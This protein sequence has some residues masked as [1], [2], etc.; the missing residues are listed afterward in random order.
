MESYNKEQ[1]Y[2]ELDLHSILRDLIHRSGAIVMVIISALMLTFM[3]TNEL[4]T[5]EYVTKAT[6]AITSKS[7]SYNISNNQAAQEAAAVFAKAVNSSI[8]SSK[9]AEL[10][11]QPKLP[12]T[13]SCEAQKYTNIAIITVTSPHPK[14][15]YEIMQMVL[16]NYQEVSQYLFTNLIVDVIEPAVLPDMASNTTKPLKVSLIVAFLS[17]VFMVGIISVLSFLRDTIKNEKQLEQKV[18]SKLFATLFF[19]YG[20]NKSIFSEFKKN[21][22]VGILITNPMTSFSYV[23]NIRKLRTRL[24]RRLEKLNYKTLL[25]GSV[26]ENE[27]KSTVAANIA[28]SLA[29]EG[30]KVLLIDG[31]LRRPA[32]H[33]LF[34]KTI[35]EGAYLIDYFLE[36]ATYE[37]ICRKDEKTGLYYIFAGGSTGKSTNFATSDRMKALIER[38]KQEMDYVIIDTPPF[39]LMGDAEGIAEYADAT[40]LVVQQDKAWASEINDTVDLIKRSNSELLGCVYNGVKSHIVSIPTREGDGYGNRYHYGYGRKSSYYYNQK[41]STAKGAK[42]ND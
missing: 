33:K 24:L 37:E 21:N 6:V 32:Q 26:L 8:L 38:A 14:T 13:I 22:T 34:E 30:K 7:Q 23:E 40:L 2:S 19:E 1:E 25:V 15:S 41:K 42:V 39:G 31:D 4:Y 12:G 18:D 29:L 20:K 3:A 5:P 35:D 10:L 36:K 17:G 11:K 9:I 27:G 28:L 16:E